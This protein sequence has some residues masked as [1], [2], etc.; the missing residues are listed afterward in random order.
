M[1][2]STLAELRLT[3]P[4]SE[5]YYSFA[6]AAGE[7]TLLFGDVEGDVH[8]NGRIDLQQGSR[9]DG[10]ASAVG[11]IRGPGSV[12]GER[13]QGVEPL[14]L[15]V[16]DVD[17][18]RAGADRVLEG[19]ATLA[20][21]VIDDVVF[22]DGTVRI[23]SAVR[24]TGTVI[25]T[26]DVRVDTVG[27]TPI[28]LPPEERLSLIAVDDV[29]IGKGS[30][31]RAV[32]R[33][34][35][36]VLVEKDCQIEG[37]LV[38][39]RKVQID[40]D[41]SLRFRSPDTTPPAIADLVPRDGSVLAQ[42]QPRIAAS[43]SD[44]LSGVDAESVA[45]DLDGDHRE[46][47]ASIETSGFELLL[48]LPLAD[49][50]HTAEVELRDHA[51]NAAR[52]SWSFVTDV[53][54]PEIAVVAPAE[55]PVIGDTTPAIE[56]T[57]SDAVSGIDPDTL[58]VTIDGLDLT[59]TCTVSETSTRCE[60][61]ELA[62]GPHEIVAAVADRAGNLGTAALQFDL[63][64]D[65]EPPS[66][67]IRQ[68]QGAVLFNEDQTIVVV[69]YGDDASGVDPGTLRVVL[70]ETDLTS[71]CDIGPSSAE[72]LSQTLSEG[73]HSIAAGVRDQAGNMGTAGSE[74]LLR[75]DLDPP[76]LAITAPESDLIVGEQTLEV[77][78]AYADEKSAVAI[79]TLQV[80][81][82]GEDLTPSC[83]R[84]PSAATCPSAVVGRGVHELATEVAD[85]H[86]NTAGAVKRFTVDVPLAIE[87]TEPAADLVTFETS[88]R[89]AGT[90]A[91]EARSVR[92]NGVW[93][94]VGAG[95]FVIE[96][97][98]LR[99]GV[100]D[101]IAVAAD[102]AG[103]TGFASRR[104]TVDTTA[105]N[106]SV[107]WP[108]EGLVVHGSMISASG[109][110]NDLRI[111]TVNDPEVV[112]RVNGAA[113]AVKNRSFLAPE[114]PLQPGEN[115]LT[116]VAVDRAGNLATVE[117]RVTFREPV[118]ES[119]VLEV[120]GNRQTAPILAELPEPLVVRVRDAAGL[121]APG[122]QVVFRVVRGDGTLDG[123]ERAV[124]VASDGEGEASVRWRLG[125][126]AGAGANQVRATA[127]GVRGEVSFVAFSETSAA[128]EIHVA[129]GNHQRGAVGRRL[130]L[131]LQAVVFD[132]GHN[133]VAGV[134]V[135]FQ[136]VEGGGHFE[137][138]ESVVVETDGSGLASAPFQLGGLPGLDNNLVAASFEGMTQ[139]ALIFKA[140]GFLLGDPG[141][142]RIA[143]VV[144]GPLD[145][146]VPGVTLR[147]L[148]TGLSTTADENGQFHFAGVP[149]GRVFLAVDSST[150][151]LPGTWSS[152]EFELVT[153]PGVENTLE[154]P[155]YILPLD[156]EHGV[157]VD[158]E[159][160]GTATLAEIPGLAL[161]IAPGSVTFPDGGRS[162]VV[163]V[164]AVKSDKVPMAPGAGMQPRLIVTIQPVGA[165]FDPPARLTLP[166]VDGL[167]AGTVTELFSFDHD[168]RDF[169]S[170]GTG[171]VSEDRT[172]ITSDPGFGIV[173]GGWHCGSP[174][175]ATGNGAAFAVDFAADG[176]IIACVG[177]DI[178]AKII[179]LLSLGKRTQD[180]AYSF[181][182]D[183]TSIA[184]Q[185]TRIGPDV[186]NGNDPVRHCP[187]APA[188][189][190][191]AIA[192]NPGKT[193][194]RVFLRCCPSGQVATDDIEIIV[195]DLNLDIFDGQGSQ[196]A[197]SESEEETRGAFTVANLNDTNGDRTRDDV[198]DNGKATVR[199]R[200]E[201]DLMKLVLDKPESDLGGT[202]TLTI[203]GAFVRIWEL[204]TKER[205][206]V[207][208]GRKIH[209]STSELPKE[210]WVEAI[211]PSGRLRDIVLTA[212]YKCAKDTVRATAVWAEMS[213]FRNS[214]TSLSADADSATIN[215]NF[216]A[217]GGQFG[218]NHVSP[219]TVNGMET[220]F[221]VT[222]PGIGAE[223]GIVFDV[224]RQKESRG[225][226]I[227]GNTTTEIFNIG[228]APSSFPLKDE[229]PND[230]NGTNDEDNQP[231]NNHIYSTDFPGAAGDNAFSDRFVLRFNFAEFVRVLLDGS[232][233]SNTDHVIEGSRCSDRI[234]WRS[235]MDVLKDINSGKWKRNGG[236]A[237]ENEIQLQHK[238]IGG[239]PTP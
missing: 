231:K 85:V 44:D 47:Q 34:G 198:D 146:P 24:G 84:G 4:G 140:S 154:R 43:F 213:N 190:A 13:L 14:V 58:R 79:D 147:V 21:E 73:P 45:I 122:T 106:V 138:V 215:A 103:N 133:P 76:E 166:N 194:G 135:T 39:D 96:D 28:E 3:D 197:I 137:G 195:V 70:D 184:E 157:Y 159:H 80:V 131:P 5:V 119:V 136:V 225:W 82:D 169:V 15:P 110:V 113:A 155:I 67:L 196:T 132:R 152:L 69:E 63:I 68:P 71:F 57:Y 174:P 139:R 209:F 126:R 208:S 56:L 141:D 203:D 237:G 125:S 193:T 53:T 134:P 89:I 145:Q 236:I 187:D 52:E 164:T 54:A 12:T 19:D 205:E 170:I 127:V 234:D 116:V 222:P 212:E 93:A 217:N 83:N 191:S 180:A 178:N 97:F 227:N 78:L 2:S 120:S 229:D 102:S 142:T 200:D 221:T 232:T 25:A 177:D 128:H 111:G 179:D 161:E 151:A 199:G 156:V 115:V 218:A 90:V 148:A 8:S 33:A 201:I 35:R 29:R 185:L 223:P 219:L 144:L 168:I 100:H 65:T 233:F 18:L 74:F 153:L 216:A 86:G 41:A 167:A 31:L 173:E 26:R 108:P 207:A 105:P 30:V 129:A 59:S 114:V 162:G 202:V 81:L 88:V 72:C 176:P 7:E 214:G 1:A 235:R 186:C 206:V 117:R 104:V 124:V 40:K 38:A 27:G 175:S 101:L 143:G 220:E 66:I 107:L 94:V 64:S 238:P 172:V 121:P 211:A 16:L 171:T 230:D 87:I 210:L 91:P 188:C 11:R 181:S 20:D 51:G 123:G 204:P 239:T 32:V 61:P 226:V 165:L 49:G 92:V 158:E 160:G 192:R 10:D 228:V 149:P 183:D 224:T 17:E 150:A 75:F 50:A 163:S 182:I 60:P 189:S 112:V 118:G 77:G 9:I 109:L 42:A 99:E 95:T 62:D 6:V 36:D 37:V 55:N 130:T 48:A 22:V 23:R 98:K 46:D